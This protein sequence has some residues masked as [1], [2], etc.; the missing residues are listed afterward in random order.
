MPTAD[1]YKSERFIWDEL[2]R[3]T[4]RGIQGLYRT[5]KRSKRIDPFLV[6]WPATTVKDQHG[7]DIEGP[8]VR[9]L[10]DDLSQWTQLML[11]AI[12]LTNAYA[13]LRV[14]QVSGKVS[15]I[16]ESHHGA[17]CWTLPVRRSGD[18]DVLGRPSWVDD[19]E[20]IGIL[21]RPKSL[22]S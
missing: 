13:L 3:Q 9:D 5:W 11:E 8:V 22:V 10:P 16:L 2:I 18:A 15:V 6:L 1:Y 14:Q 7:A 20:H 17:R 4:E 21:W 12:K 19:Q